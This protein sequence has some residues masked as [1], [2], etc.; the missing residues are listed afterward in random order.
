[1]QQCLYAFSLLH[2]LNGLERSLSKQ[3]LQIR[4]L[5]RIAAKVGAPLHT[6]V[7]LGWLVWIDGIRRSNIENHI[8]KSLAYGNNTYAVGID[9]NQVPGTYTYQVFSILRLAASNN[10]VSF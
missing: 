7:V 1:M 6:L 2:L 8:V 4:V 10:N 9:Q 3:T 5:Y